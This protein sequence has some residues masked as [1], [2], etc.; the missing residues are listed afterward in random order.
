[1]EY[2]PAKTIVSNV[3]RHD[4]FGAD[5]NMNIYRGCCHRCI[6]C[7]SRSLCYGIE[8]F[9][10]LRAKADALRIIRDDLLKKRRRGVVGTGSMS[11][12]YNPFEKDLRLTRNA[13]ELLNAYRF[14]VD[15]T[16]KSTLVLRDAAVL[17]DIQAHSP[18]I[19]KITIT[20]CDDALSA[21][22]E[23]DAPPSSERFEAIRQLS[24]QGIYAG[25]LMMPL[26]PFI[27][28][29]AENI[30]GMVARAK[31]CGARFL[32]PSLGM[33][34]RAGNREYYY[35]NLERHFPGV[36]EQYIKHFGERYSCASPQARK[37]WKLFTDECGRAELRYH[38]HDIIVDYKRGYGQI[39]M[40]KQ[41]QAYMQPGLFE[42]QNDASL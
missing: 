26:L 40:Q 21:L 18:V 34:L 3:K 12:P 13:L 8:R 33:T 35:E 16:T 39:P 1:M 4:W 6:Y 15:I 14:G 27:E 9:D 31:E 41:I 7:D 37:L 29:T 17:K 24:A 28:D 25:V 23:P 22:V 20:T 10:E 30:R 32:Y 5:Y 36:K 19:V 2:I 11:D 38:M 42:E